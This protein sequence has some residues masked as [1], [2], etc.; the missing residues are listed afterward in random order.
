MSSDEDDP[1]A[2]LAGD[3]LPSD[4]EVDPGAA[5]EE[6]AR[7]CY[8][9][10][11]WY[12]QPVAEE[13]GDG[14]AP[15][16]ASVD[17]PLDAMLARVTQLYSERSFQECLDAICRNDVI[18]ER[19]EGLI[20][21]PKSRTRREMLD[22]A[23]RCYMR[24]ERFEEA[25]VAAELLLAAGPG[26]LKNNCGYWLLR[27][28]AMRAAGPERWRE[29]EIALRRN[30][31]IRATS[32]NAWEA[33]RALYV[34][35]SAADPDGADPAAASIAAM[36]RLCLL[37]Y[38]RLATST[39]FRFVGAD[40]ISRTVLR[41]GLLELDPGALEQTG[42]AE[43]P[44]HRAGHGSCG[45]PTLADVPALLEAVDSDGFRK[46]WSKNA[47]RLEA[48]EHGE[49]D[50]VDCGNCQGSGEY[51]GRGAKSCRACAGSGK[52]RGNDAIRSM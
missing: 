22:V 4:D 8:R 2:G 41:K 43:H 33:L 48:P 47:F 25:V 6:V 13:P 7:F 44:K 30:V 37:A 9:E 49:E 21:V 17:N 11:Q 27:G 19:G 46:L 5:A 39:L 34:E 12:N 31:E 1:F 20:H 52:Q 28:E 50:S 40:N 14:A 51:K 16:P 42:T 15:Y 23:C 38:S 3:L 36:E 26:L 45:A 18:V 24:L 32:P 10:A 35:W 29:A